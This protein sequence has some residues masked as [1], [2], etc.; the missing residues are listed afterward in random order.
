MRT[1][2]TMYNLSD[3]APLVQAGGVGE[4]EGGWLGG[5]VDVEVGGREVDGEVDGDV[6]N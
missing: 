2:L 3:V 1:Y 5:E 4:G 6:G